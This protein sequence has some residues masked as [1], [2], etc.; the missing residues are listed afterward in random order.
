MID[1]QTLKQTVKKE[2]QE[3]IFL[4]RQKE[5][6]NSIENGVKEAY[7]IGCTYYSFATNEDLYDSYRL[8]REM[9]ALGYKVELQREHNSWYGKVMPVRMTIRFED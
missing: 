2:S 7:R 4:N 8:K 5:Y 1:F 6:L 9:K 3:D